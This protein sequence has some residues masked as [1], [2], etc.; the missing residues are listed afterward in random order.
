MDRLP[1][2]QVHLDFHTSECMP[3][4][5]SEFSEENFRKALELGHISSITLFSKC[6]H[7][8]SYHPTKVNKT[9][10]TLNTNLLD[11]QLK[12]CEEMGVR[13][14]IYVSAGLDE[15]KAVEYPHFRNIRRG[16]EN[17][18]LGA[19]WHG[20]CLNNDEYL[21]M[22]C[23]EV[24]EVMEMFGGR[25]DG[26]FMDICNPSPCVCHECIKTM[27]ALGLDPENPED[28]EKHRDIVY[29]KYTKRINDTVA[30]YNPDMPVFHN[31]GEVPKNDRSK[32]YVNTHHVELES[33]PTGGWGYD[34][35]PMSAA[36][37][38]VIGKEFLGMTGKFHKSWGE[39]GGYKHPNALRYEAA[40]S[41]ANGAKCS[42]GDQLHPL[43]KFEEATY[44]LIGAAYSEVEKK[45]QWCDGVKAVADVAL[46][47]TDKCNERHMSPDTGANRMML[48]GK[49]LYNIIDSECRFFDYKLIIFPDTVIFDKKL[50]EKVIMFLAS[51]GKILLSGK[52]GTINGEN[53]FTYFGIR[54][55]LENPTDATYLIPAYDEM[56]PSGIAPYLMYMHGYRATVVGKHELMASMQDSYFNRSLRRFCSHANTPNNPESLGFGAGI[57]SSSLIYT[58]NIGYIAWNVFTEYCEHG[59]Y[60]A[61]K[62]V[63]DMIERLIGETKTVTTNL[64]SNGVITL[65][66]QTEKNRLVNHLLYAVTKLRGKTEVIEDAIAIHDVTVSI[67]L[68]AEPKRVYVAPEEKDIEYKYENGV[69]SYTVPPFELHTMVVIDK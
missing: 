59:A 43:G 18:L 67:R 39:F 57:F 61:K 65:M 52:S 45:E 64:P 38:R 56:Q 50:T 25:F 12:V 49:Y 42:V 3:G 44:R 11:R 37:M 8:W 51:G 41:I 14:Q 6:H 7:G 9:H 60:H 20:L 30:A 34:H 69:L 63:L 47:V 46:F 55:I 35:F 31:C 40:L 33:L 10:P 58:N 16:N 62:I 26:V 21:D 54:E 19:H 66:E 27:L 32:V 22:L 48:E 15:R 28:V 1:F 4:V 53:F 36:Y 5:G 68:D 23:A 24:A 2:R 17:T 13:T 29:A